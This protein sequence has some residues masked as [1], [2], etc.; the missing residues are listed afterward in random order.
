MHFVKTNKHKIHYYK[1]PYNQWFI[2][3]MLSLFFA[4]FLYP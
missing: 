4:K 1:F 2:T 3:E